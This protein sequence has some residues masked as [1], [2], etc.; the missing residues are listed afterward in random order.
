MKQQA[1]VLR[2]TRN[3][4]LNSVLTVLNYLR[5]EKNV[6][7]KTA[8][9]MLD[10]AYNECT[11]PETKTMFF[12]VLLFIGDVSRQHD[13]LT[14]LNI[15]SKTGGAQERKNFRVVLRWWESR[16]P[17]HF[18]RHLE[19]FMEFS[20]IENLFYNEIRTNRRKGDLLS[21]EYMNFNMDKIADFICSMIRKRKHNLIAKHLPK[22]STGK[23]RTTKLTITKDKVIKNKPYVVVNGQTLFGDVKVK[24]GD[25]ISYSRLKKPHTL[26][27]EKRDKE[28][29]IKICNILGWS[30]SGYKE[31]RKKQNTTEQLMSSKKINYLPDNEIM[32]VFNRMTAGQRY[33]MSRILYRDGVIQDKW[34]RV[35]T[36]YKSWEDSQSNIAQKIRNTEDPVEKQ[37]LEKQLKVKTAGTQTVDLLEK[38]LSGKLTEDQINTTYTA[39]IS[40]MDLIAN[41]FVV[42]DGSG[43]MYSYHQQIGNQNIP[44]F[45]IANTLAITF[46]TTNPNLDFRNTF[47]WFSRDFKIIGKSKY[48]NNTPNRYVMSDEFNKLGDQ[49]DIISDKYGFTENFTR[50]NKSNPGIISSTNIGAC[51]EYFVDLHKRT[52]ITV[53]ELPQA[54]LFITDNEGNT[55]L[56]PKQ[57]ISLANSIGWH[58]L[59]I[60]WGLKYNSMEQYKGVE[61]CLFVSGFSESTLSQILRFVKNGPINPEDELWAINDNPRYLVIG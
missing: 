38:L 53:E 57:F 20:V 17:D 27:R 16:V 61:N 8:H 3:V 4:S 9:K 21:K 39:L 13:M 29:I 36:L 28:L 11:T 59:V 30:I 12:R 10:E 43:S 55:G 50:M 60:F 34:K 49:R 35:A 19:V 5:T 25:V 52:G 46:S 7:E 42:V 31:F 33:R 26:E 32:E 44:L 37:K 56:S 51:V 15:I 45:A 22:Y 54:L 1:E 14:R 48:V 18:Y 6:N 58:P 41:V 23:N 47:G 2:D 40:K 24:V